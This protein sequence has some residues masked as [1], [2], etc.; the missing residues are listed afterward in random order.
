VRYEMPIKRAVEFSPL[1]QGDPPLLAILPRTSWGEA[2][3]AL[4]RAGTDWLNRR[5]RILACALHNLEMSG[6]FAQN[7]LLGLFFWLAIANSAGVFRT[8][9]GSSLVLSKM[10]VL[11]MEA[12]IRLKDSTVKRSGSS[13]QP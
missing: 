11:K 8:P 10:A 9:S 4:I 12:M 1:L 7:S 3:I 6:R 13:E 2:E 5:R